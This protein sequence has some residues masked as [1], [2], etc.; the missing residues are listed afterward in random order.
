MSKK[1]FVLTVGSYEDVRIEGIFTSR[2]KLEIYKV[3]H[4]Q[5]PGEQGEKDF[6]ETEEYELD[7]E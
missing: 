1:V 5:V 4:F 3:K 6:N 7:P 2:E